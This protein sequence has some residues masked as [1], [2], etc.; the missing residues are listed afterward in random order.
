MSSNSNLVAPSSVTLTLARAIRFRSILF[1]FVFGLLVVSVRAQNGPTDW[2]ATPFSPPSIP[3]AVRN[4]YLNGWLAQGN[5]PGAVTQ[6]WTRTYDT[7]E[8]VSCFLLPI[9]YEPDD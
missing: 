1:V 9:F 3:F 2:T 8:L 6:T 4:P 5:L 7:G